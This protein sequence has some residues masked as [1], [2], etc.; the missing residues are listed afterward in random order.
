MP[1]NSIILDI[2]R[3]E[4]AAAGKA[5]SD[6]FVVSRW[7]E[8]D[9]SVTKTAKGWKH[10]RKGGKP[11]VF[12]KRALEQAH[13][14][15]GLPRCFYFSKERENQAK[16][17]FNSTLQRIA[18]EFNWRF[19]NGL[20]ERKDDYLKKWNDVY[21]QVIE[22]VASG[23]MM[24]TIDPVKKKL[25]EL[26][27]TGYDKLELSLLNLEQPFSKSFFSLRDGVNQI[28]LSRIGSGVSLILAYLLLETISELSKQSLLIL[29]D[30]PELHLHHQLRRKFRTRLKQ[31]DSQVIVSTHADDMVD[32]GDWKSVK[33][34]NETQDCL[35]QVPTLKREIASKSIAAHLDEIGKFYQD[36]LTLTKENNA[37]FFAR[38][39][40]LVEGPTDK[41]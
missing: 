34:M 22:S 35:P 41:Y 28:D 27:G 24:E 26:L 8:P 16:V 15:E 13:G 7:F 29:I 39:C 18:K 5:L 36:K 33:R 12:S 32:I 3:R 17:G 31:S 14:V 10:T 1:C 20:D 25:I 6:G 40:V 21:E 4:R 23:K 19:L 11:F 37:L 30:E 9:S 38:K 2:H